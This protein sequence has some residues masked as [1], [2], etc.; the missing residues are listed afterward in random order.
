MFKCKCMVGDEC[1]RYGMPWKVCCPTCW[2]PDFE[3]DPAKV[4][5]V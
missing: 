2:K 5:V 3:T 1:K 4:D